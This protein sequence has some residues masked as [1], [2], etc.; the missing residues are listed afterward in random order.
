MPEVGYNSPKKFC[1][2]HQKDCDATLDCH[3]LNFAPGQIDPTTARFARMDQIQM[4]LHPQAKQENHFLCQAEGGGLLHTVR[5]WP[6]LARKDA[7]GLM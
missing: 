7:I 3:A 6:G 2:P 4:D 1:L 5:C